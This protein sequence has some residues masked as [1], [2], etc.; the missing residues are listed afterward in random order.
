MA[1][2]AINNSTNAALLAIR[3]LG[4][5]IPGILEKM[6]EY[7]RKMEDE[8]LRKVDK[9]D[10]VVRQRDGDVMIM[11]LQGSYSPF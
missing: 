11:Q 1:T 3:L 6:E 4:A 7:M 8:V 10:H 5:F 2:V 9:L